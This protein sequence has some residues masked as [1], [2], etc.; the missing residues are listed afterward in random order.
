ML[1]SKNLKSI[2]FEDS[3]TRCRVCVVM[4]VFPY[5]MICFEVLCHGFRF[6]H[7]FCV[8]SQMI[9]PNNLKRYFQ[10]PT[11]FVGLWNYVQ[12]KERFEALPGFLCPA[13]GY[14]LLVGP[15][16]PGRPWNGSFPNMMKFLISGILRSFRYLL[17]RKV[18]E[19]WNVKLK[20]FCLG[21]CIKLHKQNLRSLC[22]R[23]HT[24]DALP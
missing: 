8:F 9:L 20:T 5:F 18:P 4:D 16:N 13:S 12:G 2:I 7:D 22:S 11:P 24:L 10:T 23:K 3:N 19:I 14:R 15:Q 17:F 1:L 21:R 6:S